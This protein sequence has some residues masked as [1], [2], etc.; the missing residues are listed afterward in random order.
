M[1]EFKHGELKSGRGGR[2]GKVK[3]RKQAIAIAMHESGT[4]KYDSPSKRRKSLAKSKRKEARGATYQQEREGKSR[5]GA[6]G[7][8]ESSRA[9][10]GENATKTTRRRKPA[11]RG[12]PKARMSVR[13]RARTA[14]RVK[15]RVGSRI[16][17]R[18][19]LR[20]A[21]LR[22]AAAKRKPTAAK[23]KPAVKRKTSKSR[24]SK[25]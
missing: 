3:S 9:M 20:R 8:R 11:T 13:G 25:R 22:T 6:R 16:K 14:S 18:T 2:G 4:S 5:V 19:T 21:A 24:R 12:R 10:G 17:A 7:K 1:H 15:A 23:R